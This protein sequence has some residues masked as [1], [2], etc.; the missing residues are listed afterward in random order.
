[1]SEP[2]SPLPDPP[3]RVP[4]DDLL[5]EPARSRGGPFARIAGSTFKLGVALALL[6]VV[7]IAAPW[8]VATAIDVLCGALLV[9][10]GLG[11]LALASRAFDWRGFWLALVCGA[12]SLVG[13]TAM[14]V[15]PRAGVGAIVLFVGLLL[16]FE[17][18]AKFAVAWSFR[19]AY[20]TRWVL[21]DAI[22]TSFLA[23]VLLTARGA[24]TGTL[25]GVLVG[26]NLLSSGLTFMAT[27]WTLRR[28]A[29]AFRGDL[30]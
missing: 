18:A 26:V 8:A 27:G 21:F 23:V 20:P 4:F 17:A 1:M 2:A 11:Q 13:G 29:D 19:D 16:A 28:G 15:I 7:A 30:P 22:L 10:A 24:D 12:L 25:L 3:P 14:L 6:G 5:P 9:V